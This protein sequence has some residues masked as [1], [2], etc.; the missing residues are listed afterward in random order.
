MKK[1]KKKKNATNKQNKS[2]TFSA[3][4]EYLYS[5]QSHLKKKSIDNY[6]KKKDKPQHVRLL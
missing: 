1:E 3:L 4:T 5:R 2:A 6:L